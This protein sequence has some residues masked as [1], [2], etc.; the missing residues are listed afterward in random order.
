MLKDFRA[1]ELSTR[2]YRGCKPLKMPLFLKDQLMRAASSISLNLA[3]SAGN[4]SDKERIRYFTLAFGSL[5]E[6]QA[7]LEL[8]EVRDPTIRELSDQLGAVLYKLCRISPST[9]TP[10]KAVPSED[11]L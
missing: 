11:R 1:F 2:F 6:C 10:Q 5:R 3:E 9:G 7:I 8:E 4:R